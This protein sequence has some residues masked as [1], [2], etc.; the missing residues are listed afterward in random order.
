MQFVEVRA[1][2]SWLLSFVS[3]MWWG[4][5]LLKLLCIDFHRRYLSSTQAKWKTCCWPTTTCCPPWRSFALTCAPGLLRASGTWT[6]LGSSGSSRI[7]TWLSSSTVWVGN[8]RACNSAF[9]TQVS[10]NLLVTCTDQL[11]LV[12]TSMLLN[13]NYIIDLL[14]IKPHCLFKNSEIWRSK[15]TPLLPTSN[16]Q[17]S[18]SDLLVTHNY[19]ITPWWWLYNDLSTNYCHQWRSYQLQH[20]QKERARG[21]L[22]VAN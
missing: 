3:V 5:T 20:H 19:L 12:Y 16:L 15:T 14:K 2:R 22:L 1:T 9:I 6:R 8:K 4:K 18:Y 10:W 11:G 21:D 17:T 7:P 13:S